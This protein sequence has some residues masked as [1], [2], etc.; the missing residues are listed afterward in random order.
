MPGVI[1]AQV[2]KSLNGIMQWEGYEAAVKAAASG[3]VTTIVDMPL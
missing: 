1:D 2:H 3:G